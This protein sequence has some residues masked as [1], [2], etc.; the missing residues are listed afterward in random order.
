MCGVLVLTLCVLQV[1]VALPNPP[2][3]LKGDPIW[4]HMNT[5]AQFVMFRS[6]LFT[7]PSS[8]SSSPLKTASLLITAQQ[9]PSLSRGTLQSKLFNSFKLYVNQVLVSAGPGHNV[10]AYVTQAIS[11]ISVLPFLRLDG[12]PNVLAIEC[13]FA[14]N[15][16]SGETGIMPRLQADLSVGYTDNTYV[17]VISTGSSWL[18]LSADLT[19]G[20]FPLLLIFE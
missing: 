7:V 9:S 15:L 18:A 4:H 12:E 3:D 17:D 1:V 5:T 8:P 19:G 6:P 16:S 10:P 13:F 14:S 20:Y 2:Y 11:N